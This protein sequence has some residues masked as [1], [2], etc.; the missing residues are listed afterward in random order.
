MLICKWFGLSSVLSMRAWHAIML[1]PNATS[2]AI[3]LSLAASTAASAFGPA[4]QLTASLPRPCNL[5]YGLRCIEIKCEI[6]VVISKELAI[7]QTCRL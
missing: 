5:A 3:T 4:K 7:S 6:S 1:P 2:A